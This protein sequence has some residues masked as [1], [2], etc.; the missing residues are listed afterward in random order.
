MLEVKRN[1]H[2]GRPFTES[3]C[4]IEAALRDVSIPALLCS[5]VHI[6]GDPAWIRSN[7]RPRR[8]TLNQYQ[9]GMTE[10]EMAVARRLALPAIARYRD[11][12]CT[13]GALPPREICSR[14]DV[15]CGRLPRG[16]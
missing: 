16:R 10:T 8:L 4:A 6:T 12:G 1:P 3:D 9:G 2:A 11:G 14:D 13:P 15:V 5:M 7:L